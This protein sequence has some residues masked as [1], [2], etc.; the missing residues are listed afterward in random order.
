MDAIYYLYENLGEK[1]E[2]MTI[3]VSIAG[4][5]VSLHHGAFFRNQKD[6]LA[7]RLRKNF[8]WDAGVYAITFF[9]GVGLYYDLKWLV[10]IDIIIRPLILLFAVWA[11]TRLYRHLKSLGR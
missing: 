4:I 7:V 9:M 2:F 8:V 6:I 1:A 10:Q 3:C 11:S 5:I